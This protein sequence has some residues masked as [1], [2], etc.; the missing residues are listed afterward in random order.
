MLE[1]EWLG[2]PVLVPSAKNCPGWRIEPNTLYFAPR[3]RFEDVDPRDLFVNLLL[4]P[5]LFGGLV[6]IVVDYWL[7]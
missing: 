3:T 6:L 7:W 1:S 2:W 4:I 5:Y